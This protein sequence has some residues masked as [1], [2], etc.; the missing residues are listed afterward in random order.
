MVGAGPRRPSRL[1]G[2]ESANESEVLSLD[3]LSLGIAGW[4]GDLR[5]FQQLFYYFAIPATLILVI[6]T[7]LLLIGLDHGG[8]DAGGA[9][10]FGGQDAGG[11]H[12]FG[13]HG[14]AGQ[15]A[16]SMPGD[17][18]FGPADAAHATP[19][20]MAEAIGGGLRL[21]TVKGVVAF[22]TL[23][24][25]TGA[26]LARDSG[27]HWAITLLSAIVA[28]F[29][30]MFL[31]ALIFLGVSRLQSSGNL[32]LR[33]AV[34]KTGT[35]YIPIPASRTGRGKVNVLLQERM[36]ELAAVT[37]DKEIIRSGASVRIVGILDANTIIVSRKD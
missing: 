9:H 20:P 34:G 15:G 6:Q 25:W 7:V 36:N 10:D 27:I 11:G 31:I 22:F 29:A 14:D 4:W 19:E 35:A 18:V 21:F 30:G 12:D 17:G 24:G 3:I 26:M 16:G 37:D 32:V 13:G 5:P 8:T 28:G 23:F 33:D 2:G 1:D